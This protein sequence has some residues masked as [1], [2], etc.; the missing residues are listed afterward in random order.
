VRE[1][2]KAQMIARLKDPAQRDRI[3]QDM[4]DPNAATWENQWHGS[5]GG[6]G[7][8]LVSV[9][10]PELRQFEGL[11][12][13]EIGRRLNKDPRDAVADLVVEDDAESTVVI[14]IMRDDD[15]EAALK[16]PL[17]SVGTDYE[18]RAEDGPMSESKSHPRAWGSFPRILGYYVRERQLFSLEEAVR[19]MTSRPA[20]RVG[21][22]DRGVLRPGL[23]ADVTVFDPERIRDVST[24][25]NPTHYAEGI[26]DVIVNGQVAVRDGRLTDVH[27]GR[28]LRGPAYRPN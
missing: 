23:V 25:D 1:G 9:T 2:T 28:A 24:Y 22:R 5:G 13:T 27:A 21:L 12:L 20:A 15:V 3:K 14:S 26:I 8:L 10:N 19:K 17:V 16:D 7:V 6:D 18:A 11:T 4:A